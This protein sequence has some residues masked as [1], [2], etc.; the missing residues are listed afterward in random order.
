MSQRQFHGVNSERNAMSATSMS[1]RTVSGVPP[2]GSFVT[3][4][5]QTES[6]S[7]TGSGQTE[8]T[9][10]DLGHRDSEVGGTGLG[11]TDLVLND[12]IPNEEVNDDKTEYPARTSSRTFQTWYLRDSDSSTS[13]RH[14]APAPEV[15]TFNTFNQG[16]AARPRPWDKALI[17]M[18]LEGIPYP[19]IKK[20]S[21]VA[22]NRADRPSGDVGWF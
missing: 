21:K 8:R 17:R 5:L 6:T 3:P 16:S 14:P 2:T 20:A 15:A 1:P 22:R 9:V 10:D 19:E 7:S 4:A 11:S 13:P 18:R 12:V